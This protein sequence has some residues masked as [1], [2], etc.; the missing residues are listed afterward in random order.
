MAA[1]GPAQVRYKLVGLSQEVA[2][3]EFF[4]DGPTLGIGRQSESDVSLFWDAYVSRRHARIRLDGAGWLLEDLGSTNGTYLGEER[5]D[6]SA[7]LKPGDR[8]RIGHSWF[9]F[10]V[11][12]PAVGAGPDD[13]D[14]QTP[15]APT[16]S[17]WR[18]AAS[19]LRRP[20]PARPVSL[21]GSESAAA[22]A[23]A[24]AV[25]PP[26]EEAPPA[27]PVE[28]VQVRRLP[29]RTAPPTAATPRGCLSCAIFPRSLQ[30]H[31]RPL[32]PDAAHGTEQLRA[33]LRGLESTEH[34]VVKIVEVLGDEDA[35]I[36][37]STSA[38]HQAELL[39]CAGQVVERLVRAGGYEHVLLA[40]GS[41]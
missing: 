9:E 23:E 7:A 41:A 13:A 35:W 2:G 40:S 18:R 26:A 22:S 21:D 36:S 27:P 38:S 31:A 12:Q 24:D 1:E 6:G 33:A 20:E 29:Q 15:S 11:E 39:I 17:I 4:L 30:I 25:Q 5:I 28:E 37:L 16:Q 10:Q 8:I 32:V 14:A 34:V 3:R 19:F